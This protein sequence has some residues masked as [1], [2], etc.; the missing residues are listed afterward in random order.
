M[1]V[2][3]VMFI[4]MGLDG[5]KQTPDWIK[6]DQLKELESLGDERIQQAGASWFTS[7]FQVGY[8]L[9]LATARTVISES[10]AAIKGGDPKDIL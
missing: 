3:S 2:P 8:Q 10:F 9:G 5:L 6:A 4:E 7:D 1:I